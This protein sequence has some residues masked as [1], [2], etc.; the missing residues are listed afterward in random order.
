MASAT[1]KYKVPSRV[2]NH[3][4]AITP[5]D[6]KEALMEEIAADPEI[7]LDF[8]EIELEDF[9]ADEPTEEEEEEEEDTK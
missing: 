4:T 1:V 6:F 8:L 2:F 7:V 9:V 5:E 3:I